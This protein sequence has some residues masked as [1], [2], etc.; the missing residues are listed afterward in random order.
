MRKSLKNC[1]G[2]YND[3]SAEFER[4]SLVGE[5]YPNS[6]K[7]ISVEIDEMPA[8]CNLL[9]LCLIDRPGRILQTRDDAPLADHDHG[10]KERRGDGPTD[11]GHAGGVDKQSRFD[12]ARFS[13]GARGVITSVVIPLRQ[14]CQRI[15]K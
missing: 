5:C 15:G 8:G 6:V 3:S 11:D 13:D 4:K 12:T 1:N 2:R 10:V 7:H 14:R 9:N